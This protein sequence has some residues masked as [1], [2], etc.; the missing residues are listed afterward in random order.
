M[1]VFRKSILCMSL[2]LLLT[3]VV[4]KGLAL[5]MSHE[6][7]FS[8]VARELKIDTD[9]PMP[10]INVVPKEELQ[11]VFRKESWRSY[12]QWVTEYGESQAKKT[13]DLYLNEVIGLF[14][15]KTKIIYVGNFM[16]PCNFD[17]IVAHE[18]VHYMQVMKDGQV[19]LQSMGFDSVHFFREMQASN[20][21]K[22]YMKA[23]CEN[24]ENPILTPALLEDVE[25][26]PQ[27]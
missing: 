9:Y 5:S 24:Q 1:K 15:P 23:F 26:A 27:E 19:D 13:M 17:S 6:E 12:K 4:F 3:I 8:W 2:S 20:I 7:I 25:Q 16:E 21:A 18:I 11:K 10:Q 14:N 22:K